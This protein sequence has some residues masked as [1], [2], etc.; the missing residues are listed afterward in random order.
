MTLVSGRLTRYTQT[1]S[2]V[3]EAHI[4]ATKV[5]PDGDGLMLT[6]M[7]PVEVTAGYFEEDLAPG[8]GVIN[9]ISGGDIINR[10]DVIVADSGTQSLAAAHEAALVADDAT[11]RELERLALEIAGDVRQAVELANSLGSLANITGLADESVARVSRAEAEGIDGVHTAV[12]AAERSAL[13]EIQRQLN[14]ALQNIITAADGE[15]PF[16]DD[17]TNWDTLRNGGFYRK[18]TSSSTDLGAPDPNRNGIVPV[19][20]LLVFEHGNISDT[21]GQLWFGQGVAGLW[22]RATLP[23]GTWTEWSQLLSTAD[24]LWQ[25]VTSGAWRI[26]PTDADFNTLTAPGLWRGRYSSATDTNAPIVPPGNRPTGTLIVLEHGT[27]SGTVSQIFAASSSHGLYYRSKTSSA[28]MP[29]VRLDK[30]DLTPGENDYTSAV[31][32]GAARREVLVE[33]FR[34][35]RGGS[36][37]T[38]GRGVIALRFDH[39]LDSFNEKIVP[40]L[41]KYRLP[42]GQAINP[43]KIGTGDDNMTMAAL[44]ALC[45]ESGGEVHNHGM[46]HGNEDDRAGLEYEIIDSL[47]ALKSGMPLLPIDGWMQP[48]TGGSFGGMSPYTDASHYY[49]TESGRMILSHHPVVFGHRWGYRSR[50]DGTLPIGLNH[51]GFGSVTLTSIKN[52][53]DEAASRQEG[54]VL[55]AHP[56]YLD[57]AGNLSTEDFD[58]AM[59]YL[60]GQR[61]AGRVEVLSPT[62]F[63]LA[64]AS[65]GTR[66]PVTRIDLSAQATIRESLGFSRTQVVDG[67]HEVHLVAQS[68]GPFTVSVSTDNGLS[69]TWTVTPTGGWS[70]EWLPFSIPVGA[71][72]IYLTVT[73]ASAGFAEV[74]AA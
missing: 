58:A 4:W 54:V 29:W 37:G 34:T 3:E 72:E 45:I 11:V 16:I 44:Q 64:D 47:E 55:M 5:R 52:R 67:V 18:R 61:A 2:E 14:N 22:Y 8:P 60:A 15:M 74:R 70:E 26:I 49:G 69:V 38:R 24:P 35:R 19:G 9:L 59:S 65:H 33:D 28:W 7:T 57:Q 43:G 21:V 13:D 66:T 36:I 23:S 46:T 25:R 27:I 68:D 48:G 1:P 62:A 56:N 51:Y 73:G 32:T 41:K 71:E 6:E 31:N 20:G 30:P 50:L 39:H 40:I 63:Q 10:I 17:G 12:D 53:I 42:W